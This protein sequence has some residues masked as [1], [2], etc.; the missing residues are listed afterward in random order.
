MPRLVRTRRA[1]HPALSRDILLRLLRKCTA[2]RSLDKTPV[3]RGPRAAAAG[4]LDASEAATAQRL[5]SASSKDAEANHACAQLSTTIAEALQ[6]HLGRKFS[7]VR[8]LE[9][10]GAGT[11]RWT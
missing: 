8:L 1:Q 10:L 2:R 11:R 4:V 7:V 6:L 5:S 9:T 3:L